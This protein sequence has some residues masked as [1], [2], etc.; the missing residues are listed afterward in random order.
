LDR[1]TDSITDSMAGSIAAGAPARSALDSMRS[2]VAK[3]ATRI[4]R[5]CPTCQREGRLPLPVG[6]CVFV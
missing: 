5:S 2:M 6:A 1:K 3:L 4:R